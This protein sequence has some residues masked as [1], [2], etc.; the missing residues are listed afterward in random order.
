MTTPPPASPRIRRDIQG[1]RALAVVAVVLCHAIG[2]P[3][4][5]FVGVDVFFVV[6]VAGLAFVAFNRPRA[7]Q[8]LGDAIA[9]ALLGANWRFAADGTDYFRATDA[10]SPLQHFWS[11]SVEE[12]FYLV[13]PVLLIGLLLLVPAARRGGARLRVTA[14]TAIAVV[15]AASY[16]WAA[17]DTPAEPTVAYFATTTR[18]WELAAGALLA[19]L[20]PVLARIPGAFRAV[21]GWTGLAGILWSFAVIESDSAFP[22]P[23]AL[24]PVAATALVIAGGVG[25]D[26][27]AR[28]LFP[29]TNPVGVVIGDMSYSIYLWHFPV[30]VFAA[31]LLP[32][33]APA[34]PLVLGSIALLSLASYLIVEQ[35]LHRSPWLRAGRARGQRLR[36]QRPRAQRPRVPPSWRRSIRSLRAC[37]RAAPRDGRP[38]SAT[39]REPRRGACPVPRNFARGRP[40]AGCG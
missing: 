15:G 30:I 22:A 13:W 4:G 40:G 23:W 25:G 5:G 1:L 31:V 24:L 27:R 9:A 20:A 19:A 37:S 7:E 29:L 16:A 6:A 36:A 32:A 33:D 35:P 11:L 39:S 14:G 28:H 12:Q 8:T 26:P 3:S 17:L 2:W 18:V 10:V 21:L 38:G 34:V